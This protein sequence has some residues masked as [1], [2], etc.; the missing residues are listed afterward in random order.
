MDGEWKRKKRFIHTNGNNFFFVLLLYLS[1]D[2]T[3]P[4]FLY[5]FFSIFFFWKKGT[6]YSYNVNFNVCKCHSLRIKVKLCFVIVCNEPWNWMHNPLLTVHTH[7]LAMNEY[8]NARS[9]QKQ[10]DTIFFTLVPS[11]LHHLKIWCAFFLLNRLN[12]LDWKKNH[13]K[14]EQVEIIIIKPQNVPCAKKQWEWV[15]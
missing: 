5:I 10:R 13:H 11:M 4:A 2:M 14:N 8:D 7:I 1:S 3:C 15:N 6:L 12:T 9:A